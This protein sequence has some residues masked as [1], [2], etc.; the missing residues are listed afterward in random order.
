MDVQAV[1]Q[2]AGFDGLDADGTKLIV[3]TPPAQGIAFELAEAEAIATWYNN[4]LKLQLSEIASMLRAVSPALQGQPVESWLVEGVRQHATSPDS[5]LKEW[6]N[7]IVEL[8]RQDT[9]SPYNWLIDPPS[10]DPALD[11]LQVALL[12]QRLFGDLYA[13]ETTKT[14]HSGNVLLATHQS[15]DEDGRYPHPVLIQRNGGTKRPC[16]FNESERRITDGASAV[17]KR[18][19]DALR[20]YMESKGVP[21]GKGGFNA[22]GQF[23]KIVKFILTMLSFHIDV[24]MEPPGPTARP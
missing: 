5:Q 1:L 24:D 4:G 22:A 8:G 12:V 18:G 2:R 13:L 17:F 16:D 7:L 6:A 15:Y 23:A 3:A 11:S 21:T 10:L 20:K 9:A 19:F 14:S